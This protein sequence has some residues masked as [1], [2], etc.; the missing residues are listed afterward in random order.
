MLNLNIFQEDL[1]GFVSMSPACSSKDSMSKVLDVIKAV[2]EGPSQCPSTT[3][4][5]L[6]NTYSNINCAAISKD[7]SLLLT[8]CDDS[9]LITWDLTPIS[10]RSQHGS[11]GLDSDDPSVIKLG[12]DDPAEKVQRKSILRGH[13]GPVFDLAFTAK[14]RYL[15]SVSEDTTMRLWDLKNGVNK[16]IYQGHLY[17]IWSVDADSVGSSLVTG[18]FEANDSKDFYYVFRNAIFRLNGSYGQAMA[19]RI[20]SSN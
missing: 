17:P 5:R 9:S 7:S 2:R 18:N 16:A 14:G 20:H 4:Y 10:S 15:M 8:G 3:L 11:L 12:C 6:C 1:N 19:H 13:A